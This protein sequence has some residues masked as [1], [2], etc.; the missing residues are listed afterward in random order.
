MD[1]LKRLQ[2]LAHR[3]R[4]VPYIPQMEMVECG[5]ASLAMVMAYH[6]RNV[7]LAEV[8]QACGVSRDGASALGIIT[9]ARAN[10]FEAEGLRTD[11]EDLADVP[12]PAILH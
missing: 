10:G 3:F 8:R 11:P 2:S 12:L 9:G 4:R 6:G 7:P 1:L 5:A